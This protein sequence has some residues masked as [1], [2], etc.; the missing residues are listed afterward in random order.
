MWKLKVAEG[1]GPYLFSTNKYMGRQIW[2][3][4]PDAG[5]PEERAAVE[6]AREEY[7]KKFKKDRARALHCSDLLMRMQLKKE[8]NNIDLSIPP[9]RLGEKEEVTYEVATIALRKAIRLNRAIQARDGHW[10]AENAGPMFFTPPLII[11]LY[12][13]G[14]INTILTW[15]H[16]KE[17]VRYFYLHQNDDGGWGFYIEG[18]STMIGSALSYVALRLLGEGPD[19]GQ[20]GAMTKARKWILDNS[21]ATGIPSWGKTYLSVLGVYEWAGC[22]PC[23]S[24]A[25]PFIFALSS[26]KN[27]VFVKTTYMPMSYLYGRKYHGPITDLVKSLRLEIHLK[28]YEE[29]NWNK[30]R[31]DC[32]KEDLYYHHTFIQDLLWDGLH[33]LSEPIMNC[34]PFN[35]IRERAIRKTV[36]Y[37]HYGAESSRYITIG[38]VEKSL[39]MMC[40]WAENP[41]GDEFK[42]HL[43]RIPDYLWLAEDGMKMQSFG[44]QLW[45][46]T[47]ATQAIIASNMADEYGDSLKK[48]HVYIKESQI[49][50]NPAGDFESMY[51]CFTKGAWTFSDQDHGW[52][53]SDCT[54]ES[55]KCL[56]TLSQMPTEIVGEKADNE[57]LYDAVNGL[58][59]LQSPKSGGFAVWE[60]PVPLTAFQKYQPLEG[61]RTNL[62]QTSWAMLGLIYSGQA[63]RDP[64]PL[65]RAAKLLINAQMEDGDFPQQEITG[66]VMK[67]CMLHYGQYRNIFPMWALGEYC[68]RVKF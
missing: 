28:P 32:C 15:E 17:L 64:T 29:I 34:W 65:H 52:G 27:V 7:K 14:A 1:H 22:N 21:G 55:L 48:A 18:H 42:H 23:P 46:T 2:E 13:S 10:A 4:D 61:N 45:D 5:T 51:R 62:V 41:D 33:Y 59:F 50:E 57:S 9:V 56:L 16:K 68:K 20:D 30:A 38:C 25:F 3:F 26:S 36:K 24:A 40:W 49:Q 37:M 63:E 11:I 58:L 6:E 31:H 67:N 39:Q 60:P 43:A 35:K 8:N 47:F 53:A 12:I 44:S 66:I 54:A 19:S